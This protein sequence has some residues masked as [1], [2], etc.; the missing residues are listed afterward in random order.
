MKH[1]IWYIFL[2]LSFAFTFASCDKVEFPEE[3][4]KTENRPENP[5]SNPGNEDDD[6]DDDDNTE[7]GPSED[8]FL[9]VAEAQKGMEGI[10]ACVSGYIVGY[11]SGTSLKNAVFDCPQDKA[12]TNMLL[13]DRPDEK[14]VENCMPIALPKSDA[15][16]SRAELNLYDHPENLGKRIIIAGILTR[17][18][19]VTGIKKIDAFEWREE[20]SS[21]Q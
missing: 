16:H 3:E 19:R 13:A 17:Y 18:F 20:T 15:L 12:N 5:G 8:G 11:I 14:Q 1:F 9:S 7:T 10:Q 4:D 2:F 6:N 21:T